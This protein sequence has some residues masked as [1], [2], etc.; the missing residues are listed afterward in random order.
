MLN[1]RFGNFLCILSS[2]VYLSS[3]LRKK[4]ASLCLTP[5]SGSVNLKLWVLMHSWDE[6]MLLHEAVLS[7]YRQTVGKFS[8]HLVVFT[9]RCG[10]PP[11]ESTY[12][13]CTKLDDCVILRPRNTTVCPSIGSAGA[14]WELIEHTRSRAEPN[15]YITFLDGDDKYH[16]R[17][18]LSKI[19][20]GTIIPQR[21]MFAW[22]I[23]SGRFKHQCQDIDRHVRDAILEGTI[24]PR[25]AP[26][27]YCHPRFFVAHLILALEE[28]SM[29]RNNGDWLQKA[30]DRPLVYA[31]LEA[32]RGRSVAYIYSRT[33]HVDYRE[34]KRNGLKRFT[35][36]DRQEDIRAVQSL[37][38]VTVLREKIIVVCALYNR[39]QTERFFEQFLLFTIPRDIEVQIHIANNSPHRQEEFQRLAG[40][41]S[42]E[43]TSFHVHNMGVNLGGMARFIVAKELRSQFPLDFVVFI[44]DDQYLSGDSLL[45]LW[46]QREKLTMTSW[47]GK[48][49]RRRSDSYWSPKYGFVEIDGNQSVPREWHYGGTGG[50]I[51][52]ALIFTDDRLFNI[53]Q[54]YWFVEDLWLSYILKLN[55]WYIKRAFIEVHM[56]EDESNQGQFRALKKVKQKMFS[57]LNSCRF[58]IVPRKQCF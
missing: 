24:S 45:Q 55:G 35:S 4:P 2:I 17:D 5:E 42:V 44:D 22:G 37:A 25:S 30:T 16:E 23:Q 6:P 49:W 53:P 13:I 20:M 36:H 14:K 54:E 9:D 51:V 40:A 33:P 8:V 43:Q 31:A 11:L 1:T 56:D 48:C 29:K 38:P 26:W 21:P 32:T 7:V 28:Q 46:Q 39:M 10:R 34:T 15:D 57:E 41:L 19:V 12:E 47:F 52:D 3:F 18:T 27:V 50:A 58:P